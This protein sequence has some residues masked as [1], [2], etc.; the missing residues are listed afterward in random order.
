MNEEESDEGGEDGGDEESPEEAAFWGFLTKAAEEKDKAAGK[1]LHSKKGNAMVAFLPQLLKLKEDMKET[2]KGQSRAAAAAVNTDGEVQVNDT[3]LLGGD[4]HE[5]SPHNDPTQQ[6]P[7]PKGPL[8]RF[9]APVPNEEGGK[10]KRHASRVQAGQLP[11][12][13]QGMSKQNAVQ[14]F[15]TLCGEEDEYEDDED[16]PIPVISPQESTELNKAIVAE[17]GELRVIVPYVVL[18]V[19]AV[20]AIFVKPPAKKGTCHPDNVALKASE[21]PDPFEK[22]ITQHQ[23][24]QFIED[25]TPQKVVARHQVPPPDTDPPKIEWW[26]RVLRKA[27]ADAVKS[28]KQAHRDHREAM[29]KAERELAVTAMRKAAK[30]VRNLSLMLRRLTAY[31]AADLRINDSRSASSILVRSAVAD[32]MKLLVRGKLGAASVQFSP[33][34]LHIALFSLANMVS[35]Y[36]KGGRTPSANPALPPPSQ[37]GIEKGVKRTGRQEEAEGCNMTSEPAAAADDPRSG[38]SGVIITH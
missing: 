7:L 16:D 17:A 11:E 3:G 31:E 1:A 19:L 5:P 38:I 25:E 28:L 8:K 27:L 21:L 34:M 37:A 30:D 22:D 26:V 14:V 10:A 33:D 23:A 2:K 36:I 4:I 18:G 12:W 24:K 13:T 9:R 15:R 6:Q 35:E 20:G 29:M 32:R